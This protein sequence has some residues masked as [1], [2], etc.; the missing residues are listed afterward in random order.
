MEVVS[1][2]ISPEEWEKAKIRFVLEWFY[3]GVKMVGNTY[4][5]VL[6][7]PQPF[8]QP[9]SKKEVFFFLKKY[10]LNGSKSTITNK[11]NTISSWYI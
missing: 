5:S 2:D 9:F 10:F 3:F 4:S 6:H 1:Y 7:M 11:V 8:A